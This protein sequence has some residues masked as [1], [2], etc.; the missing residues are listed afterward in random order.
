[1]GL[2]Y[3]CSRAPCRRSVAP[4]SHTTLKVRRE[5]CS[6]SL[7]TA[8]RA[9]YVLGALVTRSRHQRLAEAVVPGIVIE[10]PPCIAVHRRSQRHPLALGC[11]KHWVRH[12]GV[13]DNMADVAIEAECP[14]TGVL[15]QLQ[16]DSAVERC[17]TSSRTGSEYILYGRASRRK[18]RRHRAAVAAAGVGW[19]GVVGRRGVDGGQA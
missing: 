5:S 12:Y 7:L 11:C 9:H 13:T 16:R 1:M 4:A 15:L 6:A 8:V 19:G 18:R 10:V 17:T 14:G 2:A 3:R